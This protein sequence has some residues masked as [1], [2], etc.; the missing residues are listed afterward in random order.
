ML[1][2]LGDSLSDARLTLVLVTHD[3]DVARLADRVVTD[4]G[5][6]CRSKGLPEYEL[7]QAK[8]VPDSYRACAGSGCAE[9]TPPCAAQVDEPVDRANHHGSAHHVADGHRNRVA[10]RSAPT[11]GRE[12]L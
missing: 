7:A 9:G 12:I 3:A 6:T 8:A 4:A 2:L 10:A 1:E 11:S 5:R